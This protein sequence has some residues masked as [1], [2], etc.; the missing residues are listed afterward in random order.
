MKLRD[1]NQLVSRRTV[2]KVLVGAAGL[3]AVEMAVACGPSAPAAPPKATSAPAPAPTAAPAAP[4]AKPQPPAAPAAAPTA[5]P[6]AAAAPTAAPATQARSGGKLVASRMGDFLHFDPWVTGQPQRPAVHSLHNSL[7]RYDR[8]LKVH[9]ELAESWEIAPDGSSLTLKLR[10]GV[11]WH[12]GREFNAEDVV[13]NVN[14]MRDKSIGHAVFEMTETVEAAEAV[15]TSTV[16]IKYKVPTPNLWEAL[17]FAPMIAPESGDKVKTTAIGTGPFMLKEWIPNDHATFVKH[18]DYWEKGLPYLDEVTIKSGSDLQAQTVALLADQVQ[19]AEPVLERDI[20]RLQ[21]NRA[22]GV[23]TSS[24]GAFYH[25]SMNVRRKPFDN[26]LVR[27][28]MAWT[29]DRQRIVEKVLY[30]A[31]TIAHGVLTPENWGYNKAIENRY[32]FDLDKAKRMLA[33]AGYPNG[34]EATCLVVTAFPQWRDM[35]Q[36]IQADVKKIGITLNL[37]EFDAAQGY[38]KMRAGDFDTHM[39]H[40][41][42]GHKDPS[43]F[44]STQTSYLP[45]DKIASGYQSEEY[46]RLA[47][48]AQETM[49]QEKR[50]QMY[51]RLQEIIADEAWAVSIAWR[52]DVIAHRSYVKGYEWAI[53]DNWVLARTWLDK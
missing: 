39:W 30:G 44:W 33:E 21:E 34:F 26:K 48:Q 42:R 47:R 18:K 7:V 52:M 35:A 16:R 12:N 5:A 13:W 19:L 50:K 49:D 20:P 41:G 51:L 3:A 29:I 37:E 25:F 6:A 38:P 46:T 1:S 28:A 36:I 22:L 15:D 2:L 8:Q 24:N 10:Q 53:D 9:P 14:R 45:S 32:G 31:S 4:A 11:K 43:A 23:T 27:Q 40:S 17:T